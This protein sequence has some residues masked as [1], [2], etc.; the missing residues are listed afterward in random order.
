MTNWFQL[1]WIPILTAFIGWFTNRIAIRM[2]FRPRHPMNLGLFSLQGI[3]P[4][5]RADL[6]DKVATVIER[7]FL[8]QHVIREQIHKIDLA[9]YLQHF[10]HRLVHDRLGRYFQRIPLLGTVIHASTMDGFEKMAH[11]AIKEEIEPVREK[12]AAEVES[13]L[14]V[15]ELVESRILALDLEQVET[16][17]LSVSA[18]EFRQIELLGGVLGFIVGILQILPLLFTHFFKI[19]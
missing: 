5:R 12:L 1:L 4:R 14:K 3:I 9:P 2:L 6:A 15:K 19:L 8:S 18:R 11:E 13:K 17:I 10:I 16:L 7:E